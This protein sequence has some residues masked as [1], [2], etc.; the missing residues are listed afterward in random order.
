MD[1]TLAVVALA[2]GV[3]GYALAQGPRSSSIPLPI[4]AETRSTRRVTV[5]I[6]R[7]GQIESCEID[8]D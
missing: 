4:D 7:G 5:L 2:A 3:V 1:A 8:V 6:N